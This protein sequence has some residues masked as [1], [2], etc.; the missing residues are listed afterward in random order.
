MRDSRNASSSDRAIELS[1]NCSTGAQSCEND[2]TWHRRERFK[3]YHLLPQVSLR[4]LTTVRSKATFRFKESSRSG[5]GF[6]SPAIYYSHRQSTFA[7]LHNLDRVQRSI[8][9]LL[10]SARSTSV[11]DVARTTRKSTDNS[12]LGSSRARAGI[13]LC[14]FA[15]RNPVLV[16]SVEFA[17]KIPAVDSSPNPNMSGARCGG[18]RMRGTFTFNLKAKGIAVLRQRGDGRPVDAKEIAQLGRKA[19]SLYCRPSGRKVLDGALKVLDENI[20]SEY[21]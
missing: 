19:Q 7:T 3:R 2:S 5:S 6:L 13:Y 11:T 12:S 14:Q 8:P 16:S 10:K 20:R 21:L 15:V 9:D 4:A 18:S 1:P 17:V